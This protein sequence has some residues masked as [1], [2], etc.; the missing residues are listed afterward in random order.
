MPF[1]KTTIRTAHINSSSF[2]SLLLDTTQDVAK[3]DELYIVIRTANVIRND[4][5]IPIT[6]EVKETFLGFCQLEDQSAAGMT[7]EVLAILGRLNISIQ[8]CYGQGYDGASVMSG[9]YNGVQTKIKNIQNNAEHVHCASHNL[10]LI[11]NGVVRRCS[12]I[13]RFFYSLQ[14]VTSC[15]LHDSFFQRDLV[16]IMIL[17]HMRE[18]RVGSICLQFSS[19]FRITDSFVSSQE[20][21]KVA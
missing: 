7:K 6:F 10:N 9:V 4:E 18:N 14:N 2:F 17:E 12:E 21:I 11:I 16:I 20:L 3:K 13:S 19:L 8:K 1:S 5:M 15:G